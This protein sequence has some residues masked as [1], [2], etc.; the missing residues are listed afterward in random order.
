[1]RLACLGLLLACAGCASGEAGPRAVGVAAGNAHSCVLDDTGRVRCWGANH[2]GQLGDGTTHGRL[3]PVEVVGLPADVVAIDAQGDTTC[4]LDAGGAVWC[5]GHNHHGQLGDGTTEPR[6]RPALVQGLPPIEAISAGA[7]HVCAVDDEAGVWCWG[8]NGTGQLGDGTTDDRHAPTR[9][10]FANGAVAIEA[11][12]L[13]SC[14]I[15]ATRRVACWGHAP[16]APDE[17]VAGVVDVANG[18]DHTCAALVGGGV[19]CWGAEPGGTA[20]P[21]PDEPYPLPDVRG[22]VAAV[23][24]VCATDGAGGAFCWGK[25]D[26]GQLG[27]GTHAMHRMPSRV[28][29]TESI[30]AVA[31]GD[32]HSCAV[33]EDGGAWCWGRNDLGQLG[34]GTGIDSLIPVQPE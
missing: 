10:R 4:A 8:W 21:A 3:S 20:T 13:V 19:R 18:A 16:D 17:P 12:H 24:H 11:G 26:G 22:V 29:S 31:V 25:N 7:A 27:D 23:D 14:A 34:D 33:D 5:W 30:V 2:F 1:M 6:N 15:D 32:A 28:A 9:A